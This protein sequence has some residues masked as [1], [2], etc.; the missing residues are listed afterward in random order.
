MNIEKEEAQVSAP[1]EPRPPQTAADM[2]THLHE[3]GDQGSDYNDHMDGWFSWRVIDAGTGAGTLIVKFEPATE[4]GSAG[5]A[6]ELAW[7]LAPLAG[8]DEGA[9]VA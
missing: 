8:N 9:D 2:L 3:Q 6:Q 7:T 5:P 4:S 1:A